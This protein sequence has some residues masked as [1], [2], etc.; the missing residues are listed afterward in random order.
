M[1]QPLL[2]D[3]TGPVSS[4]SRSPSSS[5][6]SAYQGEDAAA[7]VVV[8]YDPLPV[9]V[10]VR[11]AAAR[12]GPAVP[13]GG[14]EHRDGFARLGR[15]AGGRPVRRLRGRGHP[16][17]RQPAGGA[18]P[19]GGPRRRGGGGRRRPAH[20][21]DAPTRARRPPGPRSRAGSASTP[22]QV[23]VI[24]PDV[25]G[26]FG[27]KIGADPE[28]VVVAWLARQ[29]GRPV[30]WSETRSEN[31]VGMTHGPGPG[32]DGHDR[33]HAGTAGCSPTGWSPAGRGAYPRLGAFLP[34]PDPDDGPR[35]LRHRRRSSRGRASVVT[36]TTPIGAYRGAGRPEATAAIER[37]MDL[38]AAEIGMDPAEVRR[39][40]LLPPSTQ[41]RSAPRAARLRHRRLRGRAR[42]R[43]GGGRLRRAARG[44]GRAAA[45]AA[46]S[47][48][49]ASACRVYVEIT[50]RR[51]RPA[52]RGR[53]PRSRCI[54]DG[55]RHRAHR[56][57]AARPGPRDR[58][59]D[60]GQRGARHPGREDHRACTA[61]PTWSRAAAARSGSRSLQQGGAAVQQASRRAGRA[62]PAARGRRA[63]GRAPTTSW[64]TPRGARR[65]CAAH[66]TRAL[67]LADLAA[68][69]AA[70]RATRCS[71]RRAPTFPFGAHVAVV[72]V[73][74]ETG[75]A[76][77]RPAGHRRRRRHGA[78][79]A[80][81]RGP[82][83]RRHRP[84][85]RAGAAGGGRLR[86]RRQPADRR[87]SPTTRSCRRPSCPASSWSTWPRRRTYNPLGVKGIGEAGTIGATPA[88]QNA[89]VDALAHLGVR[90]IDMPTTPAAGLGGDPG[91]ASRTQRG[92]A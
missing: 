17:D 10:D 41:P 75:K 57:L 71:P 85:R 37:A 14:H 61:T 29:L 38:F 25:G 88:V 12:R 34:C 86:R 82:A 50:G 44:A 64:S 77:L 81:R 32:P 36:N 2:A 26:G 18:G 63:G 46:T 6:R 22:S 80:A 62:G 56:H 92:G 30:R 20:R 58:V 45:S 33:R 5:P 43:P 11:E 59:G 91:S 76:V 90:H 65:R 49:S 60:A 55:T 48:S 52:R 84:G 7:L 54:P 23:R 70:V 67:T 68:T 73:D 31:L 42:P 28:H 24:T 40:N 79:P 74:T 72:E 3:G 51:W 1:A 15:R 66:R 21:L 8:D 47:S 39:R 78:Q 87:R 4:A 13:R 53:T 27:A 89:V 83:A 19:A 9:V 16:R 35:R 69:R